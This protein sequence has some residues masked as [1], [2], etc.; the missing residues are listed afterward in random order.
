MSHLPSLLLVFL[1][2]DTFSDD[3]R[4]KGKETRISWSKGGFCQKNRKGERNWHWSLYEIEEILHKR[5]VHINGSVYVNNIYTLNGHL[6]RKSVYA[7][8]PLQ[9]VVHCMVLKRLYLHER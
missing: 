7:E 9:I 4:M 6:T 1:G 8:F 3:K 2:K 5:I